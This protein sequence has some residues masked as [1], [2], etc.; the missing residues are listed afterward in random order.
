MNSSILLYLT[1]CNVSIVSI[2]LFQ[3]SVLYGAQHDIWIRKLNTNTHTHIHIHIYIYIYIYINRHIYIHTHTYTHI[4]NIFYKHTYIKTH[5]DCHLLGLKVGFDDTR[6]MEFARCVSVLTSVACMYFF[7][8][9]LSI[10]LSIY[11]TIYLSISLSLS[12]SL[13]RSLPLLFP[14]NLPTTPSYSSCLIL[15]F[16]SLFSHSIFFLL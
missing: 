8:I 1:V 11:L 14:L 13:S 10:Y 2:L 4:Y 16:S 15:F 6:L 3:L 7:A 9:Y 12:L 5:R